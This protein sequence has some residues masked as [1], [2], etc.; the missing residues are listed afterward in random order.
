[1]NEPHILKKLISYKFLP[2]IIASFHDYDNIYLVTTYFEGKSLNFFRKEIFN[3]KQ[4][5]FVSACIIQSLIYLRK[6]K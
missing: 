6:E 3:E 5:K 1:M 2:K 4:I